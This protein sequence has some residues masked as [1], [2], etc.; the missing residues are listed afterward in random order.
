[1]WNLAFGLEAILLW[2]SRNFACAEKS[3]DNEDFEIKKQENRIYS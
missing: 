2:F 3:Q 1:M